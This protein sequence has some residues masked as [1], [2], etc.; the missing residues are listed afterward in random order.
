ML[1]SPFPHA[2][3]LSSTRQEFCPSQ[4]VTVQCNVTKPQDD[5]QS[6]LLWE[7]QNTPDKIRILCSNRGRVAQT[8]SCPFGEIDGAEAVDCICNE[9]VIT[10]KATFN[11]TSMCDMKLFCS[12]EGAERQ[13]VSV[14][15]DGMC[16]WH[17][18]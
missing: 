3:S 16:I 12:N 1:F 10:S 18:F 7:C 2:V 14:T 6:L 8:I 5:A 13:H 11:T 17:E 4:P 9:T 15:I